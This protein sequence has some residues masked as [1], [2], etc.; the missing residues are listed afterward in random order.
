MIAAITF[1]GAKIEAK[2]R[3]LDIREHQPPISAVAA[4]TAFYPIGGDVRRGHG[5]PSIVRIR[6]LPKS[7]DAVCVQGTVGI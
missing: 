5:V 1:E 3:R 7:L 2:G 6:S 4:E